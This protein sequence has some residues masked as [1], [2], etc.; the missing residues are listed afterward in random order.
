MSKTPGRQ[1]RLFVIKCTGKELSEKVREMTEK[2]KFL[3][4]AK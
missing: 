2:L 1:K 3:R 4:E